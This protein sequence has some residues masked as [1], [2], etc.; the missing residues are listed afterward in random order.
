MPR[1]PRPNANIAANLLRV[2]ALITVVV[3]FLYSDRYLF[4]GVAAAFTIVMLVGAAW[5]I[6]KGYRWVRWVLLVL[7]LIGLP[8]VIIAIPAIFKQKIILGWVNIIRNLMQLM[9]VILLFIPYKQPETELAQLN[10]IDLPA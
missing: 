5:L 7:F 1:P 4:E 2:S 6:S 3:Y 8:F 10:D 9:A